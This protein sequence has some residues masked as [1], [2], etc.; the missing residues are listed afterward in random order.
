MTPAEQAPAL[1]EVSLGLIPEDLVSLTDPEDVTPKPDDLELAHVLALQS[2]A[3][4]L[5]TLTTTRTTAY[6]LQDDGTYIPP[7]PNS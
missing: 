2:I 1:L 7:P 3:A 4:S 5:I 6:T